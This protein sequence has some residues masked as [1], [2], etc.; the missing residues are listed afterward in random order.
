MG[1]IRPMV[2]YV[3][4]SKK[5]YSRE[6]VKHFENFMYRYVQKFIKDIFDS[7]LMT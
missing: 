4:G 2:V 6:R 5:G 3:H 1:L 7:L